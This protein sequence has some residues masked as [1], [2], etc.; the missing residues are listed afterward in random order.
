MKHLRTYVEGIVRLCI[1]ICFMFTQT[2][3]SDFSETGFLFI[4]NVLMNSTVA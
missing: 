2:S 3:K 4:R 1:F